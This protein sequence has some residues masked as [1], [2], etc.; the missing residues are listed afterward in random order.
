MLNT[1]LPLLFS[2]GTTVLLFRW[3][4]RV[5]SNWFRF[6]LRILMF[7]AAFLIGMIGS[8]SVFFLSLWAMS[9]LPWS[10]FLNAPI[11]VVEQITSWAGLGPSGAL[12][13]ALIGQFR[14][15]RRD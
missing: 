2:W 1:M 10:E 9:G 3:L 14:K 12:A 6:L 7:F 4:Q 15:W 13:G 11:G 8:F 5:D